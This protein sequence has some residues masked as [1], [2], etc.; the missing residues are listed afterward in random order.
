MI[1]YK[2]FDEHFEKSF[3]K[4]SK[5]SVVA[6]ILLVYKFEEDI[7]ICINYKDLNNVIVKNCYLIFL[8]C[9]TFD[10]LYYIKIYI[11]FDIIAV[12]NRLYIIFRDE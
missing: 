5:S 10:V 12:F 1:I 4:V 3:I 8:I 11:K 7:R 9:E 6:L 2:Y